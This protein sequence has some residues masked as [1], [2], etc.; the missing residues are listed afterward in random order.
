MRHQPIVLGIMS[1][2]IVIFLPRKSQS[3]P[4]NSEKAAA[5]NGTRDPIHPNSS[6]VIGNPN[7]PSSNFS[8]ICAV[9]PN[10]IPAEKAVKLAGKERKIY[11]FIYL[12]QYFFEEE[13]NTP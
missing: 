13:I 12:R 7:V 8:V 4:V 6:F 11:V 10:A 1:K 5:P 3:I 9:H 2:S